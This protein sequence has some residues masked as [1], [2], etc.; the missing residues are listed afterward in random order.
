MAKA[1][2]TLPSG[3]SVVIE[4]TPEEVQGL[5]AFYTDIPKVSAPQKS[6]IKE[7]ITETATASKAKADRTDIEKIIELIKTSP[8]AESIEKHIL[9][10]ANEANRVLV[11]LYIVHEYLNN[12]FGLST[13]EISEIAVALSVKVSRQNS[14]RAL[15]FTVPGFVIKS[16]NPP[17]YKINRRGISHMKSVIGTAETTDL[18]QNSLRQKA[19]KNRKASKSN[20]GKGPQTFIL[21]L[22][23]NGFFSEQRSISDVQRKLE[24]MGHIY[25]QTSLSTPLIRLVRSNKLRRVKENDSWNYTD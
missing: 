21:E 7:S 17:R 15:K 1:S 6:K 8:E 2:F 10:Q 5:L 12:A 9:D 11:P 20:K 22:K 3:T 16:G 19:T 18:N 24:E 13:N 4:G 23:N 14:L 25:A